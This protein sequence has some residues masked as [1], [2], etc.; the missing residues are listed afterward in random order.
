M[1]TTCHIIFKNIFKLWALSKV[2]SQSD[3]NLQFKTLLPYCYLAFA[4]FDFSIHHNGKQ[5]LSKSLYACPV[6]LSKVC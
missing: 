5:V 6:P 1:I 2:K 3:Y 4:Y